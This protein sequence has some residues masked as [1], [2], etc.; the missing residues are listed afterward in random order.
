MLEDV[1]LAD[2]DLL[3]EPC[4]PVDTV[5][6]GASGVV[7]RVAIPEGADTHIHA[8]GQHQRWGIIRGRIELNRLKR[9]AVGKVLGK[10]TRIRAGVEGQL[11]DHLYASTN[12]RRLSMRRVDRRLMPELGERAQAQP[13]E[14]SGDA[15][16]VGRA[17]RW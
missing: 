3:L 7:V 8:R 11:P 2:H 17:T 1:R 4:Q 6:Q 12:T 5:A 16:V 9:A 14:R 10:R 13:V 15:T